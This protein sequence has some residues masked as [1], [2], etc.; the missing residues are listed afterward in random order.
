[1]RVFVVFFLFIMLCRNC[2]AQNAD[3]LLN[4]NIL[5]NAFSS[6]QP[7]HSSHRKMLSLKNRSII[8]KLNPVLYIGGGLMYFYQNVI[9]EQLQADCT[10]KISCS[11]FT[12]K[13]IEKKGFLKGTLEGINQFY[14]CFPGT[15]YERSE[16][17][18]TNEGKINNQLDAEN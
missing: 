13:E 1:M 8:A 18:I 7:E 9:S 6:A 10:Y 14:N 15:V 12:K 4:E 16:Y 17:L 2:S 5:H 11:E 3:S